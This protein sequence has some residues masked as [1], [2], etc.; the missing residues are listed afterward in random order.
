MHDAKTNVPYGSIAAIK[1]GEK[2]L[3]N[4]VQIL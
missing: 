2:L 1:G 3:I 4:S